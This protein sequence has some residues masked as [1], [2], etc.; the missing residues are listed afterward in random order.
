MIK[1]LISH[2]PPH[3][4]V[5][6]TH[7]SHPPFRYQI[8]TFHNFFFFKFFTKFMN[9]FEVFLLLIELF[10]SSLLL[11]AARNL[12]EIFSICRNVCTSDLLSLTLMNEYEWKTQ[13]SVTLFLLL[14]FL[15]IS[16]FSHFSLSR[17]FALFTKFVRD[18]FCLLAC[19][20]S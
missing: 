13:K 10:F 8:Y 14:L 18:F 11:N 7:D 3:I 20:M 5:K 12:S 2:S 16:K 1:Y 15:L 4:S 17:V 6:L 19:F 9:F